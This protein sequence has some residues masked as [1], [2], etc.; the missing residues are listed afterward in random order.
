MFGDERDFMLFLW[1]FNE[2]EN[3]FIFIVS[4]QLYVIKNERKIETTKRRL[5]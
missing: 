4:F 2:Y 3:L 5:F 1:D